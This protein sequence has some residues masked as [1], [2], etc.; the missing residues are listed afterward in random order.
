M[1]PL[2]L[3]LPLPSQGA[4]DPSI[5]SPP[6]PLSLLPRCPSCSALLRPNVIWFGEQLHPEV[7]M[8]VDEALDGCD[9]LL[10][11]GTSGVVYVSLQCDR[12]AHCT[13]VWLNC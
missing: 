3:P 13:G 11:V 1:P 12:M 4:P 7:L 5:H 9:L 8:A 10:V 2:L 6:V